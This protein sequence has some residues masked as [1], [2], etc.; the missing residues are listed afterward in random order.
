MNIFFTS[1]EHYGHE[2]IIK[3][4]KRPFSDAHEMTLGLIAN[5][6]Q[7]VDKGDL[8]YHLGDFCW[9]PKDV[10]E[11]LR[12][13][14]GRH[15]LVVGNHDSCH[16]MHKNAGTEMRK[17]LEAGF[18]EVALELRGVASYTPR[19]DV[20]YHHM[21]YTPILR[22]EGREKYKGW[23]PIPGDNPSILFHGHI[24]EA[25]RVLGN[26]VNVGVDVWDYKPTTMKRLLDRMAEGNS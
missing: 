10:P 4:C 26:E 21:P 12:Q 15:I 18:E 11:I 5:H 13:L 14:N 20:L 8:V 16:P 24:H 22:H 19:V 9:R 6:N 25:R 23:V 3:Y 1:D 7:V 17:Y 2:A